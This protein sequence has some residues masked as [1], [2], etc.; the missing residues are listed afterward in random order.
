MDRAGDA[1]L[2]RFVTLSDYGGQID[3][4]GTY[5]IDASRL[6]GVSLVYFDEGGAVG[7]TWT[8]TGGSVRVTRYE[9]D[10]I[11]GEV[12]AD[13]AD[14]GIATGSATRTASLRATFEAVRLSGVEPR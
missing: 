12:T 13:L 11:E 14:A 2:G 9:D 8:A 5:A 1:R 4:E 6:G 10:R 3:G 7:G